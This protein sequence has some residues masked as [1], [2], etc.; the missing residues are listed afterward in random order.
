M[1][2]LIL[3]LLIIL[4]PIASLFLIIKYWNKD[5]PFSIGLKIV[6]GIVFIITGLVFSYFA[7]FVSI[8]GHMDGGIKCASGVVVFIPFGLFVYFV[9]I[10][11]ML[12]LEKKIREK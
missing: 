12:L 3:P 10:P 5:K 9:G 11:L 8:R 6:L 1:K 2:I 4:L 7:M